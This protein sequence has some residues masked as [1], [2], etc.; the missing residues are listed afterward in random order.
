MLA[1][2]CHIGPVAL[3]RQNL[4]TIEAARANMDSKTGETADP[5]EH[6]ATEFCSSLLGMNQLVATETMAE[7]A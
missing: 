4:M 7:G 1:K 2:H 3:S 6:K 5:V